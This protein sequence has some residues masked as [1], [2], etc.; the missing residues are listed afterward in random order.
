MTRLTYLCA[1]GAI[2][3]VTGGASAAMGDAPV[4]MALA[5]LQP[6]QWALRSLDGSAAVKTVCLGDARML[7]QIRH[8]GASCNKYIITNDPTQAVVH[9]SCAGVGNGRTSIR[10]ETPRV[11]QIES[12]GIEGK[13]PFD[14]TYEGRRVGECPLSGATA[15]R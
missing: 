5:T 10:V 15:Q 2:A 7:L 13:Q 14:L 9:Y 4:P 1:L 3:A 12:Q 6:G 8:S 11:I